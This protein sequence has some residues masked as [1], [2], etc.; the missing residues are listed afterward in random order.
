[1][2]WEVQP[3]TDRH[4]RAGFA[5]GYPW[6]DAYLR[7]HALRNQELGYGRTY[8]AVP[9]GGAS[10]VEG[11]YTLSMSSVAFANLPDDFAARVPK[12]PMPVAHMGCLAVRQDR[13]G[14]GLGGLLLVD[15]L[16]RVI[17]AAEVIA[18]RAVEVKAIDA[19]ARD[20]YAGYG[21]LPFR[22]APLHL[23]LPMQTVRSLVEAAE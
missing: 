1:M 9:T 5:C 14:R 2:S 3:L 11:F 22:D 15:A 18:A 7:Q 12:Y 4:D 6:L 16:R 17:A 19:K 20:W 8:V 13:Q 10:P 21:F 23:Y